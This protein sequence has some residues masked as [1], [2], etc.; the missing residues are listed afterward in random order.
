MRLARPSVTRIDRAPV[1]LGFA[2]A[3]G[4]AVKFSFIDPDLLYDSTP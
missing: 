2:I 1:D 4:E 3:D